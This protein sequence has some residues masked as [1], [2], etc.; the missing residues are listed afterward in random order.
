MLKF[1]CAPNARK[2]VISMNVSDRKKTESQANKEQYRANIIALNADPTDPTAL[3]KVAESTVK[4]VLRKINSIDP[5]TAN[6]LYKN[7]FNDL[8]N[9]AIVKFLELTKGQKSVDIE[10]LITVTRTKTVIT[11][12][13]DAPTE[14]TLNSSILREMH[15][16][17]RKYIYAQRTKVDDKNTYISIDADP[18]NELYLKMP[19]LVDIDSISEVEKITDILANIDLSPT[20]R[21]CIM[22]KLK[23][24][25]NSDIADRLNIKPPTVYRHF[26]RIREK[27]HKMYIEYIP[28]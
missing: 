18:E 5:Q 20:E 23:G 28:D 1:K 8:V 27:L 4:S 25:S 9:T 2:N 24:L 7:L 22:F 10:R 16:A 6:D 17:V 15:R 12:L 3:Q 11:R 26:Q 14:K 13:N 19:V 21:K